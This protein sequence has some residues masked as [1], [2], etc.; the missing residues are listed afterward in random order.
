MPVGVIAGL[1]GRVERLKPGH[2]ALGAVLYGRPLR[3]V[4]GLAG[5]HLHLFGFAGPLPAEVP[6]VQFFFHG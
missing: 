5:E 1:L 2:G 3:L 6:A 4:A